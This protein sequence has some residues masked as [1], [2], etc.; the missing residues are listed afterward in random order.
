LVKIAKIY[1]VAIGRLA[2]KHLTVSNAMKKD[3]I[4]MINVPEKLVY[5][6]YDRATSKFKS[7]TQEEKEALFVRIGLP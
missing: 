4:R 7:L 2:W 1:E 6:V 5:V 3:L